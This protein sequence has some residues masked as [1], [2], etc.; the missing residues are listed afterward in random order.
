MDWLPVCACKCYESCYSQSALFLLRALSL[1]PPE[2]RNRFCFFKLSLG[3]LALN[4]HLL[5]LFVLLLVDAGFFLLVQLLLCAGHGRAHTH[6]LHLLVDLLHAVARGQH[7]VLAHSTHRVRRS[8]PLLAFSFAFLATALVESSV[9]LDFGIFENVSQVL[10]DAVLGAQ[11][12]LREVDSLLVAENGCGVRS[13]E[14]LFHAHVVICDGEDGSAVL[15]RLRG[16]VFL[17]ILKG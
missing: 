7:L 8:H 11:V 6:M 1:L 14:L 17:L 15:G 4:R 9:Q 12:L 16:Q 2:A 3:S 13:Q 10:R 5:V